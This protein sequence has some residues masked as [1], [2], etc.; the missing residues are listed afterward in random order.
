LDYPSKE[1]EKKIIKRKV[2]DLSDIELDKIINAIIKIRKFPLKKHPGT[3]E[4]I[5]WAKSLLYLGGIDINNIKNTITLLSKY[6]NDTDYL[7]ASIEVF[8]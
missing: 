6:K 2:P 7:K 3:S 8:I 5:E 1:L 4:S